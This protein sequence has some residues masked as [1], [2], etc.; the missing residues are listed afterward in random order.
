MNT[1]VGKASGYE[2][3]IAGAGQNARVRAQEGGGN[4]CA[5]ASRSRS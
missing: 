1:K 5:E 3:T 2:Q 4:G